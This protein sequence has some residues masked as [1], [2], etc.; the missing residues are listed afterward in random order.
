MDH[1]NN[2]Q[3]RDKKCTTLC[4]AGRSRWPLDLKNVSAAPRLYEFGFESR[5]ENR[6]L[7]LVSVVC[8]QVEVSATS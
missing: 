6:C 2:S 8:G 1:F 7:S 3:P 5:C 4:T